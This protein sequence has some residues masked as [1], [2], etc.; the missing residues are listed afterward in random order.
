MK[1]NRILK[2]NPDLLKMISSKQITFLSDVNKTIHINKHGKYLYYKLYR[3]NY[4]AFVDFISNLHPNKIYMVKPFISVT[5]K[6]N[7][8]YLVLSRQIL[9]TKYSDPKLFCDYLIEQTS[10]AFQ[11]FDVDDL[12][13]FYTVLKYKSVI[14]D[15]E[16]T[17]KIQFK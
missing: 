8:P 6:A 15:F 7:D 14:F 16:N 2:M 1:N 3:L 5:Y 13:G 4:F 17:S 12:E 11:Q 9:L 10:K